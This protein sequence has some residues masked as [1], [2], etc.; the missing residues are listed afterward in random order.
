MTPPQFVLIAGPN[1]AGKSTSAPALLPSTVPYVNADEIA[2]TLTGSGR[3]VQAGR[4]LLAE[5][6]KLE[7]ARADFGV[8]TTLSSRTLAP[9]IARLRLSGYRFHLI[10]LW[11]PNA[12][13]AVARV[14]ER[15]RRGGHDIPEVTIR[16]RYAAGLQNLYTLYLPIA[17]VWS[18][19][20]NVTPGQLRPIA[21]GQEGE[22]SIFD[23]AH[24]KRMKEQAHDTETN[25]SARRIKSPT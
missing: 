12:D 15:V 10:F 2:K 21:A 24:W 19:F 8:E 11:L 1:G 20:E 14:V 9:R 16:R 3:D 13:L 23:A 4:L 25:G 6:E 18:I 17:D 7:S 5:W 22:E